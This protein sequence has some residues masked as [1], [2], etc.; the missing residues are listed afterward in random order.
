MTSP[1]RKSPVISRHPPISNPDME[2]ISHNEYDNQYQLFHSRMQHQDINLQSQMMLG[3]K[4]INELSTPQNIKIL[5]TLRDLVEQNDIKALVLLSN[6]PNSDTMSIIRLLIEA[7]NLSNFNEFIKQ[8]IRAHTV[9]VDNIYNAIQI[10]IQA[11]STEIMQQL[12]YSIPA[13]K[14]QDKNIFISNMFVDACASWDIMDVN[15][16]ISLK[17]SKVVLILINFIYKGLVEAIR[18]ER[19][20]VVKLILSNIPLTSQSILDRTLIIIS[21]RFVIHPDI[22][23]MMVIGVHCKCHVSTEGIQSAMRRAEQYKVYENIY[24]LNNYASFISIHRDR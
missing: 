21:S 3:S 14:M 6:I 17:D 5:G 19:I 24:E 12:W 18:E 20:D 8:S 7:N 23:N 11:R 16:F 13:M 10:G 22:I 9:L 4:R 1:K 15:S 2:N